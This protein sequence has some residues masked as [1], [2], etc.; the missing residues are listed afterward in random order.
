MAHEDTNDGS[1]TSS[2]KASSMAE[3]TSPLLPK[4]A[5]ASKK[6]KERKWAKSVVYRILVTAFLVSLSFGVT[7]VPLIYVFGV[8]T[9]DEY[10]Q[11]HPL[12]PP[13]TP[14][15]AD[16]CK[17]RSIEGSTARAVALLGAGT[18][19]FGVMNLFVTGWMIKAWGIKRALM[20]SIVW[21][22]IRLFVQ[23]IGVMTGAGVGIIIVQSSQIITIIGGPAGY[24]LA[25]NSYA[26][27]IVRPAER[28]PTL[29]RL[30]GCAM[31]GT[32]I[33]FLA[34]GVL[35]D[36]FSDIMPFRVA[37]VLFCI[38]AAYTSISLPYIPLSEGMGKKASKSI[39]AFF[40]P[41]KMFTPRIWTLKDGSRSRQY[42]VLLLGTGAFLAVFAT[43]YINVLLQMYATDVYGFGAS[44][45][46][47]LIS[48]NFIIRAL[49]LTFAFPAIIT[50]GRT[51]LD[52]HNETRR[53]SVSNMETLDKDSSEHEIPTEADQLAPTAL[54][55]GEVEVTEPESPLRRTSTTQTTNSRAEE[56]ETFHF[57]L[58]YAR[59]SLLL[60]GILTFLATFTATGWQLYI[61]AVVLPFAAGTG[62]AAKG[63]MLQMCAPEEK[64]D[65]LSAIS[66]LETVARLSTVS[67]F[68]V[69][70]SAFAET[71]RPSLTFA[72]NGACAIVGF[73][74]LVLA[75]FPPEGAV[76]LRKEDEG[77]IDAG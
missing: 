12:P 55:A 53:H 60:D 65:A 24:L 20:I 69:I 18:T 38:S 27:E 63:V 34:G 10:Y 29:G 37:L 13:G 73:V 35:E 74:V 17:V 21:P 1:A 28:T 59:Y 15:Y 41:L 46:S 44:D 66:L 6:Q 52:N 16:R 56:N 71:G 8:M 7:Q 72:V 50:V 25:L 42:G 58:F 22:A 49:F 2:L 61:V 76:R 4:D 70:F 14:A 67:I 51:W 75:R 48:L 30:Q 3:E 36:W 77:E 33:G 47:K 19:F 9:C 31:F 68:G 57:D 5:T 32:A 43:G 26:T 11:H 39:G 64:T 45:N 23:N 40:E 54:P 62:S